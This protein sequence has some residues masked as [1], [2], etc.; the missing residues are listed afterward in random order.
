MRGQP[1]TVLPRGA[2]WRPKDHEAL[3]M[4]AHH[5]ARE[6]TADERGHSKEIA[7]TTTL[8]LG[9]VF[10]VNKRENVS[11]G[12]CPEKKKEKQ[13]GYGQSNL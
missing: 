13:I 1:R 3:P 2:A 7:N 12:I 5:R 4:H 6:W 9:K 8:F 11:R 10:I